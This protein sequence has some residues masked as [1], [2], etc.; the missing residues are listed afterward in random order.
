[1]SWQVR[2]AATLEA[3]EIYAEVNGARL[4][5]FGQSCFVVKWKTFSNS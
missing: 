1:M 5:G 2:V 4:T 3:I